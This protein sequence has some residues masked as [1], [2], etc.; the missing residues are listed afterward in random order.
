MSQPSFFEQVYAIVARIPRGRVATYGQVAL[1]AGK[2]GGART[3]GWA[4]RAAPPER[5][6]P[7]HR[8]VARTGQLAPAYVF[9]GKSAQQRMLEEEGVLFLRGGRIDLRAS[10]WHPTSTP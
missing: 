1:L 9:G 6:L 3:V 4:M 10:L 7:C 2:P 5:N 8:V